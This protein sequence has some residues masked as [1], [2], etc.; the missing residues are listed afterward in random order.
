MGAS[1]NDFTKLRSKDEPTYNDYLYYS[2]LNK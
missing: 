2:H 1:K